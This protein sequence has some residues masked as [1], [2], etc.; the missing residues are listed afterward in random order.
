MCNVL[1]QTCTNG[2]ASSDVALFL[3]FL[4][5][6]LSYLMWHFD[7]A[8]ILHMQDMRHKSCSFLSLLRVC[9]ELQ[10]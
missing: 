9:L 6:F 10:F 8:C 7:G 3:S 2:V 5:F 1:V 4:F